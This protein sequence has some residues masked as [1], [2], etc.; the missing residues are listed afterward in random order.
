MP[1]STHRA[2]HHPSC[3][4]API[5][6]PITR[7]AAQQPPCHPSPTIPPITIIQHDD[8][9]NNNKKKTR[10]GTS[11]YR[12]G[13]PGAAASEAHGARSSYE[14][15]RVTVAGA[16]DI[17]AQGGISPPGHGRDGVADPAGPA[18]PPKD[19]DAAVAD[20][21]TASTSR[22]D[23]VG[24]ETITPL[25]DFDEDDIGPQTAEDGALTAALSSPKTLKQ[26]EGHVQPGASGIER[27][28]GYSAS[29][30][31]SRTR[32]RVAGLS[33]HNP[34]WRKIFSISTPE[35]YKKQSPNS[36][37]TLYLSTREFVHASSRTSVSPIDGVVLVD[38]TYLKDRRVY[39]MVLL[40]FRYGREDE[41]V[42][43]LKF[44]TEAILDFK[45]VYP[46]PSAPSTSGAASGAAGGADGSVAARALGCGGG[47]GSG[48][49]DEELTP[50]QRNLL[51]K[52]GNDAYPL[53]LRISPQA[54]PSVRL[55]PARPYQGSPLGVSYDLK[56]YIGERSDEKPH[57][58]NTVRMALRCVQYADAAADALAVRPPSASV[59]KTFVFCPGRLDLQ[60]SLDRET[61]H[62]GDVVRI[63]VTMNNGSSKTVQRLKVA[64]L[65]HVHVCMFTHGR[66]KNLI[67]SAD[68]GPG[69]AV[70]P[71]TTVSRDFEVRLQS[72]EKF[73][74][75]LAVESE[76]HEE[77][78]TTYSL[79]STTVL[80]NPREKNPY[81][82]NV[83]YEVKVKA[84]LG[85]IDRPLVVR[86]P[87]RIMLPRP[88]QHGANRTPLA[89]PL[90]PD[91]SA[92]SVADCV[93]E[94]IGRL[95]ISSRAEA[96]T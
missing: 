92:D 39:A 11:V 1:P 90:Q 64:V 52:L 27:I 61:Y 66:F 44:F 76:F 29:S 68:S 74:V 17:L 58:R 38:P 42:M 15:V 33:K 26:T 35:V 19:A 72:C 55:H 83:S 14:A 73:P 48:T 22:E 47:G 77:D 75:A 5:V 34:R 85:C 69:R 6:T 9:G 56:V 45:Q 50:L 41:E 78:P 94:D 37:L 63:H 23:T 71:G 82:V 3:R 57:K 2:T 60:A 54:P 4:P 49:T 21:A 88:P 53:T 13:G 8:F 32:T 24:A 30:S 31:T 20:A 67:G 84:I 96:N 91:D 43:G 16:L 80:L 86:L 36:R 65:Q 51:R 87:F 28:H 25:E 46:E 89:S 18:G 59:R 7:H 81:G 62:Q 12:S 10:K 40:T 70:P 93:S 79:S 95:A